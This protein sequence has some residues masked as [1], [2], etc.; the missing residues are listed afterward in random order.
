MRWPVKKIQEVASIHTGKTP[1]TSDASNFEGDI[2]FATPSDLNGVIVV[3]NRHVSLNGSKSLTL[4]RAGAA[5]V[6]CI[7][8]V[9]KIGFATVPMTFN[10]QINAVVWNQK[11]VDDKYGFFV[12]R[13]LSNV[14]KQKA[15]SAV[16]PIL[17][18]T[19]FSKIEI[20][21]PPLEEQQRIAELLATADHILKQRELAIDKLENLIRSYFKEIVLKNTNNEML[22]EL[23]SVVELKYG[24]SLPAQTRKVGKFNVFGSNGVVGSHI[25]SITSGETVIVGRKGSFGEINLSLESCYPIDTTYYIDKSATKQ[26]IV[27]LRYALETLKLNTLN[28]SAAVPG[29]N[30]EDAYR[31][32]L[33]L[34]NRSL[35]NDFEIYAR[36]VWEI[37]K[38]QNDFISK[39]RELIASL[40]H[41]SFAVN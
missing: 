9:G 26:N 17:N 5:L 10:Q 13:F 35:Q 11:L 22:V 7:G 1:S 14:I 16:V 40:Q 8:D 38:V 39:H 37:I 6:G 4:V 29:L 31:Q 27:W 41:Q 19:N 2:P 32:K 3:T 20:P 15:V 21:L 12:L 34:I 18:K 30:R 23:G 36:K 24:K 28:K 33:Q 25:E